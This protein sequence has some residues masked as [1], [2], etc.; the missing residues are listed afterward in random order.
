MDKK[1]CSKCKIE[2][3]LTEYYKSKG[4][5]LGVRSNCI[6]C[7]K[8]EYENRRKINWGDNIRKVCSKCN[9]EKGLDEFNKKADGKFGV[10]GQCKVCVKTYYYENVDQYY[11]RHRIWCLN[12][13]E[14]TKEH[15]RNSYK[16][17]KHKRREYYLINK[18]RIDKYN[19]EWC[20]K[21]KEKVKGYYEKGKERT[22][23]YYLNN[24]DKWR[25]YA[26]ANRKT[27]TKRVCVY[28][29]NRCNT[30]SLYKLRFNIRSLIYN[31][32][33]KK[34]YSKGTKTYKILGCSFDEFKFHLERQ[35][36]GGMTWENHGEVWHIDHTIPNYMGKTEDEVIRLNYYE[37]FSPMFCQENLEKGNKVPDICTLWENPFVP[38]KVNG[39]IIDPRDN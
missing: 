4:E 29:K 35:F 10:R 9:I 13:N 31:S 21:N 30:D 28:H 14:K 24:K 12:N 15:S 8:S 1:V 36:I 19:R 2:K 6:K 17:N 20:L 7:C 27:I 26:K 25:A 32:L 5:K 22:R 23:L 38:Y 39:V 11:K 16:R 3:S 37:N 18:E 33:K 34:G